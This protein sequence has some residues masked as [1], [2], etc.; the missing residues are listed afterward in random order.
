MIAPFEV[1]SEIVGDDVHAFTVNGELDLD[2]APQLEQPLHLAIA[3][4]AQAI[5]VDLSGCEFIDSTG[6]AVL[7]SAWKTVQQGDGTGGRLVICC[8]ADQ[9]ERL[10]KL[11]GVEEAIDVHPSRDEALEALRA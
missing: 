6:L 9:V 10:F 3:D 11:T 8:A 5:L 1:G 7:V 4:G 2:T